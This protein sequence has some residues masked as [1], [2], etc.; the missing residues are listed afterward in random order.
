MQNAKDLYVCFAFN[1]VIIRV[2][3]KHSQI[4]NCQL[5]YHNSTWLVCPSPDRAVLVRAW[6]IVL[7][8]LTRHFPVTVALST[9]SINLTSRR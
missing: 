6:D 1:M 7:G 2:P 5:C 4:I 3:F 9:Q 8:S